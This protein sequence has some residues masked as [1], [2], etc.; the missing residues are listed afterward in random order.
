M[1]NDETADQH[2]PGHAYRGKRLHNDDV[3]M[4]CT[5]GKRLVRGTCIDCSVL[6]E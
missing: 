5:R 3:A 1:Q 6:E 4:D 2:V